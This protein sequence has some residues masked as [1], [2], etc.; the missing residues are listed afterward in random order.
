[1]TYHPPRIDEVGTVR[2][3]TLGRDT[4]GPKKDNSVWSGYAGKPFDT[5]PVGSR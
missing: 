5:P 2:D 3:L 4:P 1:M